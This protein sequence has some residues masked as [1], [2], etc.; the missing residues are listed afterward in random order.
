MISRIDF[1]LFAAES[2]TCPGLCRRIA[3][4]FVPSANYLKVGVSTAERPQIERIITERFQQLTS[5]DAGTYNT[6][7]FNYVSNTLKSLNVSTG[8]TPF[9]NIFTGNVFSLSQQQSFAQYLSTIQSMVFKLGRFY[10]L[11]YAAPR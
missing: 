6:D 2:K 3:I 8:S 1:S 7:L 11:F 10:R 4:P 5:V 9:A